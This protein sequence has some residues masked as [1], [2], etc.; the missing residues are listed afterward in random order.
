MKN[1]TVNPLSLLFI[2]NLEDQ[3][4]VIRYYFLILDLLVIFHGNAR[5]YISV[6][7]KYA[8]LEKQFKLCISQYEGAPRFHYT[9]TPSHTH[10]VKPALSV[11]VS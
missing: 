1:A 3:Y 7:V 9:L 4:F 5:I 2:D 6:Y 8:E 10:L 11:G